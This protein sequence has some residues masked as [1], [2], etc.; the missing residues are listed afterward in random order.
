[1]RDNFEQFID[2]HRDELDIH[3]PSD[4]VWQ[5]I[6]AKL[7]REKAHKRT[8]IPAIAASILFIV[9]SFM[10][11]SK[12]QPVTD[13]PVVTETPAVQELKEAETYYSSVVADKKS[14]LDKYKDQY[15]DLYNDLTK[16][17]NTLNGY[18]TALNEEYTAS[19]GKEV[20]KQAIIENLQTQVQI[21]D[22]QLQIIENINSSKGL[23]S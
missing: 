9:A 8:S 2:D 6:Q 11:F 10:W 16:E 21:I 5:G 14:Q 18:Y 15:P 3:Q 23:S 17:M 1:M 7:P 12:P 19:S 22:Q 4:R 13:K 20:V